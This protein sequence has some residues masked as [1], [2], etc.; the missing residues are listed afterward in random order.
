MSAFGPKQTSL[1]Y[2]PSPKRLRIIKGTSPIARP[3]PLALSWSTAKSGT[4]EPGPVWSRI[5]LVDYL[6]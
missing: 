6:K 4:D 5:G 2:K 3:R 1:A